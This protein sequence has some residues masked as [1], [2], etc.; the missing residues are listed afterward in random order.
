MRAR[1]LF[2][3]A[4][5]LAVSAGHPVARAKRATVEL[6]VPSLP[7]ALRRSRSLGYPWQ[8]SL[9]RGVKLAP[10]AHLRF[11]PE[12]EKT[13]HFY[14]AWQ[15]VQLLTRAAQYVSVRLPGARLSVGELSAQHGGNLG[16]HA[17]HESGRDVDLGF[18]MLDAAGRPYHGFAFANFDA[19]GRAQKP[20]TGLRFDVARNWELI[21]RLVTDGDARVQYVFVA[22]GLRDL[23]L[24][25]A[26]RQ[27]A[28][29]VVRERA[30]R[31]L[32]PP[33]ERHPHGNHFHVRVYCGPHERPKCSEEGPF[34]PW[35]PGEAPV[36][37]R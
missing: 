4:A 15:L 28:A 37:V 33:R 14:G 20:N 18:Y 30:A 27:N 32:V 19:R 6:A 34:W 3:L 13:E 16:G 5:L 8:G 29:R 11:V 36:Q 22:Q 21:A 24:Q 10:S 12:Y 2:L 1:L 17:S 9:A 25:E 26:K 35:Y 23:L 7:A 31:V